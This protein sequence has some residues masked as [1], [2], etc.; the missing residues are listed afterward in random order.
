MKKLLVVLFFAVSFIVTV[1]VLPAQAGGR[2]TLWSFTDE[3]GEIL[4]SYFK[5]DNRAIQIEYSMT[6]THSFP[7]R[8]DRVLPSGRGAPDVFTLESAFLRQ[9]VES[10]QLMDLTDIYEENKN[11]L[12]TYPVELATYNGRV[13]AMTWQ[14]YPGAMFYRRSLAK[15]YLGTDDPQA[16]Q[17]YFSSV[18]KMMDT[19]ALLKDKSGGSCLLVASRGDLFLPFLYS[20]MSPWIVNGR[21][22]IDLAMEK[23]MDACK[24]LYD[25]RMDGRVGQW[26]QG[27]FEGMS[28]ELRDWNGKK[29]EIF[30]YFMPGWGLHYVLKTNANTSGDWA[31]IPGPI[32]YRWGGTWVAAY[33]N[34]QNPAAARE[35]IRYIA[36]N[37]RFLERWALDKGDL[38]TSLPVIQKIKN[39]YNEPFL[40]GQ[41]HYAVFAE[42]A[43]SVNG[44]LDQATDETIGIIFREAVEAYVEGEKSKAGALAD[45]RSQVQ[46]QLKLR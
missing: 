24:I 25:E 18:A 3:L 17:K 21:L 45:F 20:R 33:K 44:L 8:L 30:S 12:M 37:E 27:W 28:D 11:R 26:S 4:D 43:E 6:E 22:V 9:Y 41:N 34:T 23:Y 31:M 7:D 16:V 46:A 35:L 15:K 5:K 29:Q 38:V 42:I 19:A 40:G 36:T 2:L 10:G 32:P 14:A 13:Y 39:R 1:N